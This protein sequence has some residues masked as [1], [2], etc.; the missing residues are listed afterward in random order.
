MKVFEGRMED[1]AEPRKI[2]RQAVKEGY[3]LI[4]NERVDKAAKELAR[5]FSNF[6][7][8]AEEEDEL[9]STDSAVCMTMGGI[10]FP[11]GIKYEWQLEFCAES[12]NGMKAAAAMM[13][14]QYGAD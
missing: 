10:L 14:E 12:W 2:D 3:E 9:R 1:F 5:A 4:K 11:D 6:V 7:T 8:V 13:R